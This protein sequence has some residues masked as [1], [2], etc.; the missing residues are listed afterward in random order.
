MRLIRA[1]IL[2]ALLFGALSL[3]KVATAAPIAPVPL[4]AFA[5]N[6]MRVGYWCG[7]GRHLNPWGVCVP[8]RR[9]YGPRF[10]GP[11]PGFYGRRR[12]GGGGFYARRGYHW[13][14]SFRWRGGFRGHRGFHHNG[15]FHRHGGR[16]R[17]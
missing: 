12:F 7:P 11:G 8:N 6:L 16:H 13:H 4:G 14:R 17:R 15:G 2:A 5:G 10:Y 9:F 1:F 3:P